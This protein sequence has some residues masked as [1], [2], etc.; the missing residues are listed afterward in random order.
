MKKTG[1]FGKWPSKRDNIFYFC[2]DVVQKIKPP[3]VAGNINV[4]FL[5]LFYFWK[6]V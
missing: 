4:I 5:L 1:R 6:Y 3:M 2:K